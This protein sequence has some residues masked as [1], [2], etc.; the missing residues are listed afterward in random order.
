[1][2]DQRLN[3]TLEP[4]ELIYTRKWENA[5]LT[6]VKT[7]NKCFMSQRTEQ[8]NELELYLIA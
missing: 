4:A 3:Q 1:M 8:A 7:V 5:G 2:Y 6:K